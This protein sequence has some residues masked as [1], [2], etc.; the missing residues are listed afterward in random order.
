[1]PLLG[2]RLPLFYR[3]RVLKAEKYVYCSKKTV[4][5]SVVISVVKLGS[6]QRAVMLRFVILIVTAIGHTL[7]LGPYFEPV[8]VLSIYMSQLILTRIL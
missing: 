2:Q 8:I 6:H 3:Q 1:M 5:F 4:L 7:K